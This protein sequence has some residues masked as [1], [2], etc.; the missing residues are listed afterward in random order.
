M[1]IALIL[2][3]ALHGLIHLLGFFNAFK[4]MELP[5][6]TLPVGRVAGL[7]WLVAA[8][9]IWGAG[10]LLAGRRPWWP[11]VALAAVAVSQALVII[12]WQDASFGTIANVVI[13]LVAVLAWGRYRFDRQVQAE[14]ELL[15][16]QA[17]A[18]PQNDEVIGQAELD[19]LPAPVRR[20]LLQSGVEGQPRPQTVY[21]EQ[22]LRMQLQPTA[23]KWHKATAY[24]HFNL[25]E[26]GFLWRVDLPLFASLGIDGRDFY[27]Q[28]KGSMQ[29]KLAS[30]FPIVNAGPDA[31]LN[32]G[33]MLRFL[34]EI[35]W[36]PAA[37]LRPY[38]R[39][40]AIDE[41][42]ARAI[43]HH[44]GMKGEGI[45]TFSESGDFLRFS[46]H[47]FYNGGGAQRY[48][49]VCTADEI[50]E[51]GGHRIPSK[52]HVS[53]HLRDG[54]WTWLELEVTHLQY[55]IAGGRD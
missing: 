34:A 19:R 49:W 8:L 40:E 5:A 50:S 20:W 25:V 48:L 46:A 39:W 2:L 24:Q 17:P 55:A 52:A 41:R 37:A 16:S 42:R 35:I 12:Y 27:Y 43:F 7:F 3:M 53:W 45:F 1:R 32:E 36:F 54:E 14:T 29:M 11:V 47:R 33:A 44:D 26:P 22:R 6:L 4:W 30:L 15:L 21:L 38:L 23:K 13:L 28:G 9:L 18:E 10:L 31:E 51:L